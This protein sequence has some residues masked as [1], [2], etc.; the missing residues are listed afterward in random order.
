MANAARVHSSNVSDHVLS[1]VCA[2]SGG[3]LSAEFAH[4]EEG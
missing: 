4:N 2:T 3:D 1:F